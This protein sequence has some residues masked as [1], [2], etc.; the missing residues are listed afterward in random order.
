MVDES[1]LDVEVVVTVLEV[2]VVAVVVEVWVVV[3]TVVVATVVDVLEAVTVDVA[4]VIVEVQ[5][6][7]HMTGQW[8]SANVWCTPTTLQSPV[9]IRDPQ[10]AASSSPWH[11]CGL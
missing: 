2:V 10:P 4:V 1:V 5:S 3:V 9:G 11:G 8:V 7:P 6:N